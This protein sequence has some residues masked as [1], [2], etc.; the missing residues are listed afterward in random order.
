[1]EALKKPLE[2]P[3][4]HLMRLAIAV[5]HLARGHSVEEV[6]ALFKSQPDFNEVKSRYY[7]ENAL[8]KGYKPFKCETIQRLGFC[9]P[10]CRSRGPKRKGED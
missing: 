10:D 6:V 9:L 2:G 5:E 4:G 3:G 8:K 1:M 7:V